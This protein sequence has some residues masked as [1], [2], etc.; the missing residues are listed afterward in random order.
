MATGT[1]R[2]VSKLF[3]DQGVL[4]EGD[5]LEVT[6]MSRRMAEFTDGYIEVLPMPTFQHQKLVLFL[7]NLLLSFV[8]PRSLGTAIMSPLRVRCGHNIFREPDVVFM[9]AE[10]LSRA[11]NA[12]SS[13]R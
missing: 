2:D 9:L 1:V 5:Y 11:M 6:R 13:P 7:T 12:Y 10:H 8:N 3:N 4:S